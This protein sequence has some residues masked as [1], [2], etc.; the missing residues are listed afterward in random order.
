[1]WVTNCV[2]LA[3]SLK[4][5]NLDLIIINSLGTLIASSFVTLYL[6]VKYK[7]GKWNLH[8]PRL[9]FGLI[10]AVMAS[11][12]LTNPWTNGLIATS[13]SMCQYMFILEGVKGV[14]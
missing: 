8:L 3:Y 14:L 10:F 7:V 1:M 9:A 13:L 5:W 4:I 12:S 6:Y 2:W 11:S